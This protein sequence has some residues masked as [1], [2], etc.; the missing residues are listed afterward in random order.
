M[1][2]LKTVERRQFF[3]LKESEEMGIYEVICSG[4]DVSYAV[5]DVGRERGGSSR[6]VRRDD[7]L[8]NADD[9]LSLEFLTH[10]GREQTVELGDGYLAMDGVKMLRIDL[11]PVDRHSDAGAVAVDDEHHV[12]DVRREVCAG[13]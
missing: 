13:Y 5:D 4:V 9:E 11:H 2:V 7:K 6:L 8:V 12:G 3:A 1:Q 10:L